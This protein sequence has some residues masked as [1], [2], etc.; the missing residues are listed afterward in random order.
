MEI[1]EKEI[2]SG[3]F[4]AITRFD[5]I[6][7]IIQY[8][9]GSAAGHSTM[10]LWIDGELNVIESQVK[11]NKNL[12]KN[13]IKKIKFNKK[14]NKFNKNFYKNNRMVGIGQNTES[15]EIT[16]LNGFNGLATLVLMWQFF[17]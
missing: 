16:S 17:L 11:I 3:D 15:K 13:L 9:A 8:G 1:D 14:F 7:Q 2:H 4:I 12:I 5:G 10:A 6:D